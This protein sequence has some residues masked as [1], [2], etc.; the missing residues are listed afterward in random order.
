[1]KIWKPGTKTSGIKERELED[2]IKWLERWMANKEWEKTSIEKRSAESIKRVEVDTS[3]RTRPGPGL[4]PTVVRKSQSQVQQ[5]GPHGVAIAS[6]VLNHS[7]FTPSPSN[8]VKYL[9]V[10]SASPR[11]PKEERCYSAAQTPSLLGFSGSGGYGGVM[12]SYMAATES[13]KAKAQARSQSTPRQSRPCT[14]ERERGSAARKRLSYP[15]LLVPNEH[16]NSFSHTLTSPSFKS[17][18]NYDYYN[19]NYGSGVENLSSCYADSTIGRD[20]SPCSTTD[21][22]WFK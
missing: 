2:R 11:C 16:R 5:A 14:P 4:G 20:I 3:C 9:K 6:S 10:R 12:P 13:A 19:Y 17:V 1:M 7:P 15:V 18:Q 8:K 22:R 21:L